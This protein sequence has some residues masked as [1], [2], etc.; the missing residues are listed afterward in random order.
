LPPA[1][2]QLAFKIS[3]RQEAI[4][5]SKSPRI[6][7]EEPKN[8]LVRRGIGQFLSVENERRRRILEWAAVRVD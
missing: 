5:E 6:G 8:D 2:L 3:K 7:A 1:H 4:L